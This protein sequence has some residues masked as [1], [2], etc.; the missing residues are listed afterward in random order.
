MVFQN[1]VKKKTVTK[2]NHLKFGG[3]VCVLPDPEKRTFCFV[4]G[5]FNTTT[6]VD[7]AN[8]VNTVVVQGIRER[9]LSSKW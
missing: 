4:F 1:F 6:Y 8:I 7:F 3:G 9:S 5:V 2:W